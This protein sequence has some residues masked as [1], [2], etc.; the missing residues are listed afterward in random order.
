MKKLTVLTCVYNCENYISLCIESVLN[1]NFVDYEFIIIDDGS[2]DKT[3]EI[4]SNYALIDSRIKY[5]KKHNTGLTSS[6]NLG[7]Q[8]SSTDFILRI[9][10]DDEMVQGR[11]EHTYKLILSSQADIVINLSSYIDQNG[12]LIKKSKPLFSIQNFL[13]KGFSPFSHSS[14]ILRKNRLIEIGGYDNFFI[15]SQDYELWLRMLLNGF[16]FH[17]INLEFTK[18]RIHEKSITSNEIDYFTF[19]AYIKNCS[20]NCGLES[21]YIKFISNYDLMIDWLN[22]SC[23]IKFYLSYINLKKFFKELRNQ[24]SFIGTINVFSKII[25]Y[26][27]PGLVYKFFTKYF[28]ILMFKNFK[29]VKLSY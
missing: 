10:A 26:L 1:Q 22:N 17:I 8:L 12:E 9:D 19:I 6:L 18:V 25:F 24:N 23:T 5:I 11:I 27:I 13:M 21:K 15:K 20:F 2:N 3:S 16:K 14:V 7:I 29:N 4:I 28:L